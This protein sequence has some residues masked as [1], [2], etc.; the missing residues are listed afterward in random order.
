[1]PH[2]QAKQ[3]NNELEQGDFP[4]QTVFPQRSPPDEPQ[5]QNGQVAGVDETTLIVGRD[6]HEAQLRQEVQSGRDEGVRL[7]VGGPGRDGGV[8]ETRAGVELGQSVAGA[9]HEAKDLGARVEEVEN[10]GHEQQTQRLGKVAEDADDGK[11]HTGEVAVCVADEDAGRVP[12]VG[13]EGARDADPGQQEIQGKEMRVGGRVRVRRQEVETVVEGDEESDDDTLRCLDAVDPGEHVDALGAKHGDAGHVDVVEGAEVEQ[14]AEVGLELDRHHNGR[15]VKVDKVDDQDGDAGQ[16][17][18]PPLVSPTNVEEVVA[19]SEQRNRLQGD[20]GPEVRGELVVGELVEEPAAAAA[21]AAT[22]AGVGAGA[23]V[24]RRCRQRRK[25][26]V[27]PDHD[28]PV[29]SA[30]CG[31][32]N[33]LVEGKRDEDDDGEEVDGGADGA[34]TLGNL[35]AR[36]LAEVAA[37]ETRAHKGRAEPADHGIAEA[38]GGDRERERGDERLAI[39]A[40]GIGQHGKRR[41]R[42]EDE[43]R[44]FS[45]GEGGGRR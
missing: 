23:M 25:R 22:S 12:V 15:D 26:R 41:A 13:E 27:H 29:A 10:L 45:A 19:D 1:M 33:V 5:V 37:A 8:Q 40:K 11:D 16:A 39:T 6:A 31:R 30:R 21:A 34:H 20:D 14:L 2:K 3:A 24:G 38:G 28:V 43:R 36:R 42:E 4:G 44:G 32:H 35:D 17:R 9:R 18:D 7:A